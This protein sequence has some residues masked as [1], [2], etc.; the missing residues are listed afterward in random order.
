MYVFQIFKKPFPAGHN[1]KL[2]FET[3][4][5]NNGRFTTSSVRVEHTITIPPGNYTELG[6]AQALD[7]QLTKCRPWFRLRFS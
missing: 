7:Q 2:Y 5:P 3:V 6:F 1:D 4:V